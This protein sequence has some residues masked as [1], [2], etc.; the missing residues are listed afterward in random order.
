M[1]DAIL[2][3]SLHPGPNHRFARQ[4][5]L[6]EDERIRLFGQIA[7]LR[8]QK[9]SLEQQ[10]KL[11]EEFARVSGDNDEPVSKGFFERAKKFF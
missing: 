7:E 8:A 6:T 3:G 2:Y 9:A 11:L 10:R 1:R 5:R 4:S